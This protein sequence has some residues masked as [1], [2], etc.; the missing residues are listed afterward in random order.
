MIWVPSS[1]RHVHNYNCPFAFGKLS[2]PLGW[3]TAPQS[4]R[5]V[6]SINI[7]HSRYIHLMSYS[8]STHF[9]TKRLYVHMFD[10][11]DTPLSYAW[12]SIDR[13]LTTSGICQ[14]KRK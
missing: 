14:V 9:H 6:S 13:L 2:D 3:N 4:K 12:K 11:V 5:A 8:W 10:T 7:G 1:D